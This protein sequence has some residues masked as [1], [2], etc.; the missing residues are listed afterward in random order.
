[1][2]K[3]KDIREYL[4]DLATAMKSADE[5][6]AAE[7][8]RRALESRP[9]STPPPTAAGPAA[10]ATPVAAVAP[11]AAAAAAAGAAAVSPWASQAAEVPKSAL[12]SSLLTPVAA[13]AAAPAAAPVTMGKEA[14]GRG[15]KPMPR[16]LV[17]TGAILAVVLPAALAVLLSASPPRLKD[18]GMATSVAEQLSAVPQPPASE[19]AVAPPVATASAA[20]T[21]SVAAPTASTAT[22]R[23]PRRQPWPKKKPRAGAGATGDQDPGL[24]E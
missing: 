1:M 6:A 17:T 16:W 22:L 2:S 5:V 15:R 9:G 8:R 10:T 3:D 7:R 4:P 12:P 21:A 24:N 13:P 19:S 23:D 14:P 11:G 20:T 18:P